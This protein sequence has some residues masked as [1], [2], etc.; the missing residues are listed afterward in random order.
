MRSDAAAWRFSSALH[1]K[2]HGT[3]FGSTQVE[4][5]LRLSGAAKLG[6]M[7]ADQTGLA[8]L[9]GTADGGCPYMIRA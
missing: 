1:A 2:F 7:W 4:Q 8:S 3:G 6:S 5:P 9:D